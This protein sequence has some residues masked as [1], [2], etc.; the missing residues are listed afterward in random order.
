VPWRNK[1]QTALTLEIVTGWFIK[2]PKC[3]FYFCGAGDQPKT[4]KTPCDCTL[5]SSI[6][7]AKI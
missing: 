1:R 3:L 4:Q 5:S 2:E 7:G 6:F